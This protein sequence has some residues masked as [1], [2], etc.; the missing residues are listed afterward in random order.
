MPYAR[1]KADEDHSGGMTVKQWSPAYALLTAAVLVLGLAFLVFDLRQAQQLEPEAQLS[2]VGFQENLPIP[3]K[4]FA[5][6][7]KR[8]QDEMRHRF[9]QAA[10]LQKWRRGLSWSAL[11]LSGILTLIA[12]FLG[13]PLSSTNS[14]P[15]TMAD[16]LGEQQRSRNTVRVI[17]VMIALITVLGLFTQQ[18]DS[19]ADR[20]VSSAKEL[21][22]T[23][24]ETTNILYDSESRPNK[25]RVA[26]AELEESIAR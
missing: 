12:G 2:P 26:L 25:A 6:A 22:Q 15:L 19:E 17:G 3:E 7:L 1:V 16:I 9:S 21:N 24:I 5:P 10:Y 23:I 4:E 13:R 8:A 11:A 18:L 20:T 14:T